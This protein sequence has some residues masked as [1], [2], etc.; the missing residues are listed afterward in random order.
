MPQVLKNWTIVLIGNL[1]GAIIGILMLKY[2]GLYK[3]GMNDTLMTVTSAKMSLTFTE[4]F[5]K[6]ILCNILVVC[7]VLFFFATDNF[8]GK[9]IGIWFP[10]MLFVFSGFEHSI[11][12]L[13]ILPLAKLQ[14][15]DMTW[16]AMITKNI[17]PVILGNIVGGAI[18]IP[19]GLHFSNKK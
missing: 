8:L 17:I 4:A 5:F 13:A 11:A 7:A 3:G 18:I 9:M 1:I 6:G 14:G 10:I 15:F 19:F 2:A 12:N 16:M